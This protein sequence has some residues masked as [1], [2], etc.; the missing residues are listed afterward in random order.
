MGNHD[1]PCFLVQWCRSG[2]LSRGVAER[3]PW[4]VPGQAFS[5]S[6]GRIRLLFLD[7]ESGLESQGAWLREQLAAAAGDFAAALVFYH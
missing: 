2:K 6:A 4:I 7:S 5:V 3:F 1:Y